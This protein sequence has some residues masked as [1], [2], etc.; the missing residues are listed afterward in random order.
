[1]VAGI[2]GLDGWLVKVSRNASGLIA[3]EARL[4]AGAVGLLAGAA[5]QVTEVGRDDGWERA[6]SRLGWVRD[7][8][9]EVFDGALLARFREE[10]RKTR[11]Q[12]AR[13][14]PPMVALKA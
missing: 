14:K 3:G 4:L 1:M 7:A 6:E 5:G 8:A 12:R 13:T 11:K 2:E 9:L 10:F